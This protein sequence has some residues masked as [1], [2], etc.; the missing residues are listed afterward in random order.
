ME[1]VNLG[2]I[3]QKLESSFQP[4]FRLAVLTG[5][6]TRRFLLFFLCLFRACFELICISR[7]EKI[8]TLFKRSRFS[9]NDLP[10]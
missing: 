3:N 8:C 9:V 10:L 1:R 2:S 4:F 5:S 6:A 7:L